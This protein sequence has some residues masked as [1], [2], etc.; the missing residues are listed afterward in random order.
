MLRRIFG[1]KRD[2]VTGKWRRLHNEELNDR[3]C[4]KN[5]GRDSSVG[6]ATSYG[7][8]GPGNESRWGQVFPHTSRPV[9][10][11]T[12]LPIQWVRGLSLGVKRPGRG[13]DHPLPFSAEVE[14]KVELYNWPVLGRTLLLPLPFHSDMFVDYLTM[15]S[16][17]YDTVVSKDYMKLKYQL[18]IM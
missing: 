15:L 4:S 14:G 16:V 3:Y 17:T 1:P 11:P 10:G 13:V 5:R 8:D 9:L 6:I 7:L 12:Q 2:E 18:Q